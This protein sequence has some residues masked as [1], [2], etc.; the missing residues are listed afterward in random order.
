MLDKYPGKDLAQDLALEQ[1][2]PGLRI[3]TGQAKKK[4]YQKIITEAHDLSFQGVIDPGIWMQ[5]RADHDICIIQPQDIKKSL[6]LYRM[7]VHVGIEKDHKIPAGITKG[8][9]QRPALTQVKRVFFD[10]Q[11]P[12]IFFLQPAKDLIGRVG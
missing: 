11:L 2:D 9:L 12:G 8:F 1:L 6:D 3:M 7:Q 4:L 5:F 10:D